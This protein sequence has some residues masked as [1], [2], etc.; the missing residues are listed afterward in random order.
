MGFM[1]LIVSVVILLTAIAVVISILRKRKRASLLVAEREETSSHNHMLLSNGD[2]KSKT[3]IPI[4]L[5]PVTALIDERRLVEITDQ[6]VLARISQALPATADIATRT[7]TAQVANSALRKTSEIFRDGEIYRVIIPSG[8]KLVP[9]KSMPDAW[10]A[11]TRDAK[12]IQK[13]A[14]LKLVENASEA[15]SANAVKASKA[16]NV[17]ANI[18][19]VAS[20]V[21]GQYYMPIIDSKIQVMTRNIDKISDFQDREFKSRISSLISLV[22]EISQFSKEILEDDNQRKSKLFALE[23]IKATATE[24][25][26]QVNISIDDIIKKNPRPDYH[27]YENAVETIKTLT[28]YQT[29]LSAVLEEISKLTYLLGRGTI[30]SKQCYAQLNKYTEMSIHTRTRLREWHDKQ[31]ETLRID[32]GKER[33]PKVGIDAVLSIPLGWIDEKNGY[34]T[35]KKSFAYEIAAQKNQYIGKIRQPEDVYAEDV[36]LIIKEGKYYYLPKSQAADIG[37]EE[38][39]TREML[40]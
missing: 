20:L 29:V 31:I 25:L 39:T 3:Y 4:E 37:S 10:R 5:L 40:E 28:E 12:H 30:S 6:T 1:L 34:N 14:N 21:V 11:F 19:S 9:S 26:G 22:G 27:A 18:M 38:E 8:Q 35:I 13:H 24:L 2:K 17:V 16:V 15:I 7:L 23:G 36:V 33:V 32:L